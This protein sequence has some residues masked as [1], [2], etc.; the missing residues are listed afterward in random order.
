[1]E[2]NKYDTVTGILTSLDSLEEFNKVIDERHIAGYERKEQLNEFYI[3]GR[4]MLDNCG[5]FGVAEARFIPA[6]KIPSFPAVLDREFFWSY[7]KTW[8]KK[9][10]PDVLTDE[11][12]GDPN[13]SYSKNK[14]PFP[15]SISFGM[16]NTIPPTRIICPYCKKG[17]EINNCHDVIKR[18]EEVSNKIDAVEYI[19][20]THQH[21]RTELL[22]QTDALYILHNFIQND[23]YI[24]LTPKKGYDTLKEN[25]RGHI[26]VEKDYVIQERD[27][28]Y[29]EKVLSSEMYRSQIRKGM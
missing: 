13:F 4:Y 20:Q 19:G 12:I 17:W 7:I 22:K 15:V 24:D 26:D 28:I 11:E 9:E 10:Q 2:R 8:Q 27:H 6:E 16:E 21:I 5:N 29:Y 23:K 1:M 25:E 3:F 18:R 14:R